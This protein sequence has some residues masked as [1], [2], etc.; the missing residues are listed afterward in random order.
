M[1]TMEEN[2]F[3]F[4]ESMTEISRDTYSEHYRFWALS[5]DEMPIR[6]SIMN[7]QDNEYKIVGIG[8]LNYHHLVSDFPT[9]EEAKSAL[10]DTFSEDKVFFIA[11]CARHE[12]Y[13]ITDKNNQPVEDSFI[14]NDC[15]R[16]KRAL[17]V[18]RF[19]KCKQTVKNNI[20]TFYVDN[21]YKIPFLIK[22]LIT[23][24]ND[25]HRETPND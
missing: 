17:T 6:I 18:Y 8:A 3:S 9:L 1:N 14:C 25:L 21:E 22:K 13:F 7:Y 19:I 5:I 24:S 12:N 20:I 10:I 4:K 11:Y 2:I 23:S 15:K 16:I